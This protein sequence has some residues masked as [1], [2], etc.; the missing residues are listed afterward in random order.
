MTKEKVR[1][2]KVAQS[3]QFLQSPQNA[4]L[5]GLA[6]YGDSDDEGSE[7]GSES[8]DISSLK[9]GESSAPALD[10]LENHNVPLEEAEK[11]ARRA[12]AR[13]WAAQRRAREG[14]TSSRDEY[15]ANSP[16]L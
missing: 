15:Q 2:D 9:V 8:G 13:E 14:Q 10:S 6:G 7:E 12:R 16:D 5:G 1:Q 4:S 11:E 3:A